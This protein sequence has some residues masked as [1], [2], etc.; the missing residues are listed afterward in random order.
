[1]IQLED[2]AM[3]ESFDIFTHICH[4]LK[5]LIL[6]ITKYG[7]IDNG[8]VHTVIIIRCNDA[9]LQILA[10]DFAEVKLEAAENEMSDGPPE[11]YDC[12]YYQRKRCKL[13]HFS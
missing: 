6:T 8:A 1:M 3:T 9:G 7:V 4:L 13:S 5:I 10:V 12:H 11:H 2:V